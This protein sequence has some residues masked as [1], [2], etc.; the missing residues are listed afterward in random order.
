[1]KPKLKPGMISKVFRFIVS[2]L[3][4]KAKPSKNKKEPEIF[5]KEWIDDHLG[6]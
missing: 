5:S 6:F 4:K 3:K 1:M 2:L